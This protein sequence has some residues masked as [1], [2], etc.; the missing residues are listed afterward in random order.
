MEKYTQFRDK[1]TGISP[2]I[3][4]AAASS[5]W[6][7]VGVLVLVLRLPLLLLVLPL[8]PL[9]P[10][11]WCKLTS[12]ILG[13]CKVDTSI[14][15]MKR[16]TDI[17]NFY[18]KQ[19]ELYITNFTSPWDIF[20]IF[21]SL[22]AKSTP[23]LLIPRDNSFY[24]LQ[25]PL[26]FIKFALGYD[27]DLPIYTCSTKDTCFLFAE[28]TTSNGKSL[29]KF[30]PEIQLDKFKQFKFK[31]LQIKLQPVSFCTPLPMSLSQWCFRMLTNVKLLNAKCKIGFID[32]YDD[33]VL[34]RARELFITNG[35][36]KSVDLG[37]HEKKQFLA[38]YA[39][40][41]S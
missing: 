24:Q 6:S 10:T 38:I 25:S 27:L 40:N 14:H 8:Y 39:K 36:L 28:G 32:T 4:V 5:S 23:V 2:F 18:P 31:T 41:H 29:L 21:G 3:P 35:K 1:A 37:I 19:G 33:K 9:S 34:D 17:S 12:W 26:Q 13:L 30:A 22:I 7:L 15:G 20:I 11:T 16:S